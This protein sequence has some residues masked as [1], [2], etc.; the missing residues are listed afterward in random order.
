VW[1]KSLFLAGA[2]HVRDAAGAAGL[3]AAWVARDGA[4][5][6]TRSFAEHVTWRTDD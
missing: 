5:G 4:V 1:S 2:A 6:M 3:A